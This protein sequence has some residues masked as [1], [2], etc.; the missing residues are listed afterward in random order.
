M[1]RYLWFALVLLSVACRQERVEES[2]APEAPPAVAAPEPI[3]PPATPVTWQ[4]RL[5]DLLDANDR[6]YAEGALVTVACPP[7]GLPATVWGTDIYTDDSSI[8]T[9]AVHAGFL[10][11]AG[12]GDVTLEVRGG[13]EEFPGSE[14]NGVSTSNWGR[15]GRSFVFVQGGKAGAE[16]K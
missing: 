15:W 14:R 12:G 11:Y 3:G 2:A 16:I 4:T 6:P 10:S 9:A 5:N 13:G 1:P 7:G 8:C